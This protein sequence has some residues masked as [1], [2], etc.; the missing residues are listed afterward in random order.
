MTQAKQ[1]FGELF[2]E[3]LD[4]C[5][6]EFTHFQEYLPASLKLVAPFGVGL[7]VLTVAMIVAMLPMMLMSGGGN[8]DVA[9]VIAG[10]S[11]LLMLVAV[12]LMIPLSIYYYYCQFRFIPES[13][14][15]P[16]S[17]FSMQKLWAFDNN[18][19]GFLGLGI[20]LILIY[21]P[22]YI[23][24]I[25]GMICLIVPG[26]AI[27]ALYYAYMLISLFAFCEN[28]ADGV[29]APLGKAMTLIKEDW[30]RWLALSTV[31][32]AGSLVLMVPIMIVSMILGM[33]PIIGSLIQLVF[34]L[35][36]LVFGIYISFVYY[37]CYQ[38]SKAAVGV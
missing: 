11:G 9:I 32:I 28:P 12:L 30:M 37:R 22:V 2:T 14:K 33:I 8:E 7:I 38:N 26:L 23:A 17:Q 15:T 4:I 10:I 27:F 1:S 35:A 31:I 3:A 6:T 24:G 34:Q 16:A 19:W 18:L 5:K 29:T 21:I 13:Y 20:L 25:I 36:G